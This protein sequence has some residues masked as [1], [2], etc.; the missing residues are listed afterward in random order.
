MVS[1]TPSPSASTT[2]ITPARHELASQAGP[3]RTIPLRTSAPECDNLRKDEEEGLK[4]S[5][6]GSHESTQP[7]SS[8]DEDGILLPLSKSESTR[9]F[10]GKLT[11]AQISRFYVILPPVE[12]LL[13]QHIARRKPLLSGCRTHKPMVIRPMLLGPTFIDAKPHI[14]VFCASEMRKR[15]KKFFDTEE[16]VRDWCENDSCP[17][18]LAFGVAVCGFAPELRA[19][20]RSVS[21]VWDT[22]L[23]KSTN[24]MQGDARVETKTR[25]KDTICGTPIQFHANG[26]QANATV[27]GIVRLLY[28]DG[29]WDIKGLTVAHSAFKLLQDESS[30]DATMF[31][32]EHE[33]GSMSANTDDDMSDPDSEGTGIE[34]FGDMS[35][36]PAERNKE[37]DSWAF[38]KPQVLHEA[39]LADTEYGEFFDWALTELSVFKFNRIPEE[40]CGRNSNF[41]ERFRS[42]NP[43]SSR[44]SNEPVIVICGSSGLRLGRLMPEPSRII[45]DP[46]SLFTNAYMVQFDDGTLADGDSGSWVVSEKDL[47]LLGQVVATDHL[48]AAYFIPA[49]DILHDIVKSGVA[50]DAMLPLPTDIWYK[51]RAMRSIVK[52]KAEEVQKQ[53][54]KGKGNQAA[55]ALP[56]SPGLLSV[57]TLD[58]SSVYSQT[59]DL[60][61][62]RIS[63]GRLGPY[64]LD[65]TT[66]SLTFIRIVDEFLGNGR[67]RG[68]FDSYYRVPDGDAVEYRFVL[69]YSNDA[70]IELRRLCNVLEADSKTEKSEARFIRTIG[71]FSRSADLDEVLLEEIPSIEHTFR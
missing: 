30:L 35:N 5:G 51:M 63:Y 53:Q 41:I 62:T 64:L 24:A 71:Q 12:R 3:S 67:E 7:L 27:G 9:Y 8:H 66:H 34:Y 28:E 38:K 44:L 20:D 29:T 56:S 69:D 10:P 31:D 50:R 11:E 16:L 6:Y 37:C 46:G 42:F 49:S 55:G 65:I 26:R 58:S 36:E 14:V 32:D 60:Q 23:G 15:V 13:V 33:D 54:N 61:G 68:W 40:E 70:P 48:G 47:D 39:T 4:D 57:E 59:G 25:F 17:D 2:T 21:V 43:R 45:I 18:S 1:P 22:D 52:M 19:G